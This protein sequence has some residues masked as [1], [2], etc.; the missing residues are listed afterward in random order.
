VSENPGKSAGILSLA[1][2]FRERWVLGYITSVK[3]FRAAG[4]M[5]QVPIHRIHT[6]EPPGWV[7]KAL[8][9]DHHPEGNSN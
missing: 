6:V 3:T 2:P 7:P 5:S 9:L 8:A 1:F 4:Q